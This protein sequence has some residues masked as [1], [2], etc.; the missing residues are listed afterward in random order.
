VKTEIIGIQSYPPRDNR[1]TNARPHG[2]QP[3]NGRANNGRANNGRIY[4][5]PAPA[6]KKGADPAQLYSKAVEHYAMFFDRPEARLRFLNNTR[7]KQV[8][9]QARL[10]Q[11]LRSFRFLK[12]TRV[13]DWLLEARCYSAILEEMRAM[14]PALPKNRRNLAQQIPAPFSARLFFLFHQSRHAFY[15]TAILF[16][17]VM[18]FGMYSLV[19]WSATQ[20]KSWRV[21]K[22]PVQQPL[23]VEVVRSTPAP[24]DELTKVLPAYDP[25]KIFLRENNR[26]YEKWSNGC[27]I[28]KKYE[29]D[30]HPRAYYTIPRGAETDGEQVSNK[31]VGIIYHT[32][33]SHIVDFTPDNNEAIQK[34]SRQLIEW[35]R[36]HKLY[37]Y[38]ID[39]YGDIY[40]IIRDEHAA[41]HAGHSVWADAKNTYVLLKD[42]LI[43]V[44]L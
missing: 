12:K 25:E 3:I 26:E 27:Q 22:N 20:F 32:P 28:L 11:S 37:N 2:G 18:I 8:E 23:R 29:T 19:N 5:G 9:R 13:Y 4:N 6:V 34:G 1:P 31:I 10:Q 24:N 42:R 41:D 35:I 44:L 33:E 39:R 16:A 36:D 21:A 14:S 38:L 30:N 40:R 43:V 7:T 17:G 15:A